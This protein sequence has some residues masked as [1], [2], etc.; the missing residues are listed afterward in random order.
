MTRAILSFLVPVGCTDPAE[1]HT[2]IAPVGDARVAAGAARACADPA[3]RLESG[4]WTRTV[5]AEDWWEPG[6]RYGGKGLTVEDF[7]GDGAMDLFVPQSG[8]AAHLIFGDGAGGFV[9]RGDSSLPELTDVAGANAADLDFDGDQDLIPFGFRTSPAVL[10]NDGAATFTSEAL[11]TEAVGCGGTASF[12]DM[13]LDGDL[14]LLYGRLADE[15]ATPVEPCPSVLFENRDGVLVDVSELLPAE[16]FDLKVMSSGWVQLDDDLWPELYLVTDRPQNFDGN[17]RADFD[18]T[19]FTVASGTGLEVDMAGM[20]LGVADLND[21]G[22]WDLAVPGIDEVVVLVSNPAGVWV[23]SASAYGIVPDRSLNQSWGWGGEF[24]D[25]DNDGD[26]DLTMSFGNDV[27]QGYEQVDLQPDEVWLND[28]ANNFTPTAAEWGVDDTLSTRGVRL[29]D[30]NGDGWLDILKRE[31]GG[32]VV[33]YV[34][35]CGDAHWLEVDLLGP[36]GNPRGIGATVEIDV[37]GRTQRRPIESGSTGYNAYGPP[38]AHFGLGAAERVDAVRVLWPDGTLTHHAGVGAD[39]RV[40][41]T[42]GVD[43]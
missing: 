18:G 37:D 15:M 23:N 25:L 28:G 27:E 7:D 5:Y 10:W 2:G 19:A 40:T 32:R 4:P 8:G 41:V 29:A 34:S 43:P 6:P 39:R 17:R 22:V 3:A 30:V 36:A 13:D 24:G 16:L 38:I 21:D 33:T 11:P 20:G 31:L 12:G 26:V 9:E 14:D 42:F 35:R 1:T